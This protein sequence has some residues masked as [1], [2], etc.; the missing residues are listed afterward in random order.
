MGDG[1]A[2]PAAAAAD[3]AASTLQ[4]RGTKRRISYDNAG[5]MALQGG[6][7]WLAEE[8]QR[9]PNLP[10]V[11]GTAVDLWMPRALLM[12]LGLLMALQAPG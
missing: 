11:A 9:R 3:M 6:T 5:G 7:G 1:I 2:A 8:Q 10:C 4:R 12:M